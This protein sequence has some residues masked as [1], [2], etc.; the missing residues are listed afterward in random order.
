[1]WE[2]FLL[3]FH[4]DVPL[5]RSIYILYAGN[6][7]GLFTMETP[8]SHIP[9]PVLSLKGKQCPLVLGERCPLILEITSSPPFSLTMN[10]L[11][12]DI[13][14]PELALNLWVFP[15]FH[16]CHPI[17]LSWTFL[18]C[19][20]QATYWFLI[21]LHFNFYELFYSLF[22]SLSNNVL[23]LF[24]GCAFLGSLKMLDFFIFVF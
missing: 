6:S 15:V 21:C 20:F 3:K 19:I 22:L 17:Q 13:C 10:T 11:L 23:S 7:V 24:H 14:C 2:T 18:N 16:L 12:F 4:I 1:M 5:C 8:F 9:T